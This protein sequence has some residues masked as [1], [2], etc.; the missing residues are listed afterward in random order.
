MTTF[1]SRQDI[2]AAHQR[3]QSFI[4]RTPI[5]TSKYINE[6]TGATIYFKAENLQKIGAFKARGGLNAALILPKNK[7]EKGL[8]THS[9]GNHAQA[10]AYAAKILGV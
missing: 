10:I 6:L 4:H 9:S 1:P 7:S 2:E 3:I 5:L 8:C